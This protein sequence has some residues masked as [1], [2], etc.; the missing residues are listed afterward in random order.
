MPLGFSRQLQL[1]LTY[2]ATHN[3]L[4]SHCQSQIQAVSAH[5]ALCTLRC[6]LGQALLPIFFG[7]V[8]L[9]GKSVSAAAKLAYHAKL[10]ALI[11]NYVATPCKTFSATRRLRFR[12]RCDQVKSSTGWPAYSV[13]ATPS[14]APSLF[15]CLCLPPPTY[16]TSYLQN[17]NGLCVL[18]QVH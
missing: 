14:P 15:C 17:L 13:T 9:Y 16:Q 6:P 10:S 4:R 11:K 5:C 18:W 8:S 1:D 2:L 7:S 3:K 12:C